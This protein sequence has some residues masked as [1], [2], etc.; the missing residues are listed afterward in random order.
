MKSPT[1]TCNIINTVLVILGNRSMRR[2]DN[3]FFCLEVRAHRLL[4]N[5]LS[6]PILI[7]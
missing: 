4:H 3:H 5:Q 2:D 1:V 6:S 7:I